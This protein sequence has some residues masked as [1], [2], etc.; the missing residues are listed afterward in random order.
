MADR[1]RLSER[2][3]GSVPHSRSRKFGRPHIPRPFVIIAILLFLCTGAVAHPPEAEFGDWFRSLK[4]PGT[5][6][7]VR[8]LSCCS[9]RRAIVK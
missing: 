7:T 8:G 5:E 4:E 2:C 9:P 6:G 1:H 3:R